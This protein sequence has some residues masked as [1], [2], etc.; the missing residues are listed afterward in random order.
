MR[1]HSRS[2]SG[3]EQTLRHGPPQHS[4]TPTGPSTFQ[5]TPDC[6]REWL[7]T[8]SRGGG[9]QPE[10]LPARTFTSLDAKAAD[11][12][13]FAGTYHQLG[14]HALRILDTGMTAGPIQ[15]STSFVTLCRS[16]T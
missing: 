8:V 2:Q 12:R 7:T 6:H 3:Q 14:R 5:R 1:I 9:K 15:R 11:S 10:P 13:L 16:L 4:A